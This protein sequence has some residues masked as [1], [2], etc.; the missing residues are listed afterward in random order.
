[1]DYP[2]HYYDVVLLA[3]F[4]SMGVGVG[5]GFVTPLAMTLAIGLSGIV[6]MVL[7][8]HALFVNGPIDDVEELTEEVEPEKLPG[9]AAVAAR[10]E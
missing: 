3:I 7:V 4:S 9:V 10:G 8:S 5:V 6:A 1:M 2:M